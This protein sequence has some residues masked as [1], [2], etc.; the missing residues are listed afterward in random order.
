MT[1]SAA[2][3]SCP[4]TF[5]SSAAAWSLRREPGVFDCPVSQLVTVCNGSRPKGQNASSN[6]CSWPGAG[7][8][9]IE[10]GATLPTPNLPISMSGMER[11]IRN[12]LQ[13]PS[14][15]MQRCT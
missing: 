3:R 10:I 15:F 2:P 14:V 11:P 7:P 4:V 6:V 9:M 1:G 5:M 13:P 8:A 12:A